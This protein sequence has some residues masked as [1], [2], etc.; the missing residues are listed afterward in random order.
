MWLFPST[1]GSQQVDAY[2]LFYPHPRICLLIPKRRERKERERKRNIDQ[3]PLVSATARDLIY[4]P[5]P[6]TEPATQPCVL[7]GNRTPDFSVYGTMLQPREPHQPGLEC[8]FST[9]LDFSRPQTDFV[10]L[11]NAPVSSPTPN[12]H[13]T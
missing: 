9:S 13:E 4:G 5:Q 1:P 12:L 7:T 8:I 10:C 3:L 2:F 6:G 11:L